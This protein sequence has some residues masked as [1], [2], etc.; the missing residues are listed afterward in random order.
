MKNRMT[1]LILTGTDP[2]NEGLPVFTFNTTQAET[3]ADN[4]VPAG[5]YAIE[6]FTDSNGIENRLLVAA[7]QVD[8]NWVREYN[9]NNNP[10]EY[11]ISSAQFP[12]TNDIHT[13]IDEQGLEP[14]GFITED[15][16]DPND[17]VDPGT[18]PNDPVD[19]G[20]DP[21]NEG[22]PVFDFSMNQAESL[23]DG[24][25]PERTY[26]IE[27]FF[28]SVDQIEKRMLVKAILVA[29]AWQREFDSSGDPLEL[30]ISS[31]HFPSIDSIESYFDNQNLEPIGFIVEDP[32]DHGGY[33]PEDP[34][35]PG[36]DPE[37]EGLPVFDLSMNQAE[38][39]VDGYAPAGTYAIEIFVDP[40]DEIERRMLVKAILVADAWERELDSSGDP[41]E[42]PISSAHFP[43]IDSIESYFD[44]QNLEPIGFIVEDPDD[45]GGYDPED[46]NNPGTDPEYEGL[47]VFDLSMNQAESL[48]D[49]YAPAGTY[50]IEIFVDPIDEIERRMLVKAILVADAW[51]RE[52]DSSGDP[53]ELPISSAHFPTAD[54]IHQYFDDQN[55]EP[56]GFIVE[57]PDDHGD[58]GPFDFTIIG[59]IDLTNPQNLVELATDH[60]SV[61]FQTWSSPENSENRYWALSIE[62]NNSNTS[63]LVV[64]MNG[65][66]YSGN[67]NSYWRD[68]FGIVAETRMKNLIGKNIFTIRLKLIFK[69]FTMMPPSFT[70]SIAPSL[71]L[72][73]QK[74][75]QFS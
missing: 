45:H 36:T 64:D 10:I 22:L 59:E 43:S 58:D 18:D 1:P 17:P 61:W 29:G 20:T 54:S 55:L 35:N 47:P 8:G 62:S 51:E 31:A 2:E 12:T 32:D 15:H 48:V 30:P 27:I 60:D 74:A 34:N 7:V 37:N 73:R 19:P 4:V 50:A 52:L 26:A 39:L 65:S 28:D 49:G 25:A 9:S 63:S 33:D 72:L 42:L 68:A 56:I 75:R 38:S 40:I 44:N 16:S 70:A 13:Y 67:F 23:V 24:Y 71:P 53:L 46:P 14:N 11:P 66:I 57:D 21:E 3:L 5:S 6:I 69:N 41:L